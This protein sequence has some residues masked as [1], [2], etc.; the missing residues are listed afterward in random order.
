VTQSRAEHSAGK[1]AV[2]IDGYGNA[3]ADLWRRGLSVNR[4][5]HM[6]PP[7]A[8]ETS[9]RPNTLLTKGFISMNA[10]KKAPPER[11]QEILRVMSYLASPFG[12][13]E[14]LLLSYGIKDQDYT[15]DGRGNPVPTQDGIARSAFVPWQYIARRP[16]VNYQADLPGF[17][18][19]SHEAQQVI[20]PLGVE[21]P[22][23]GYYSPTAFAKGLTA[24]MRVH[25][26]LIDIIVARRPFSDYDGLIAAWR[27][28][29]GDQVR[30]EYLQAMN[31]RG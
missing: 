6:L 30:T 12:S 25:D 23:R 16:H 5:Y 27:S 18:K 31:V 1:Y 2:A 8:A 4:H 11:I 29:A 19:A 15:L 10:L 3:W 17:A 26:G 14:D 7:F 24:D 20:M 13:E 28:E 9:I 21:D 22:T